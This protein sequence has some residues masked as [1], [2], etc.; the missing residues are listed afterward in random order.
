MSE[1]KLRPSEFGLSGLVCIYVIRFGKPVCSLRLKVWVGARYVCLT[2]EPTHNG[3]VWG[4]REWTP[5]KNPHPWTAKGA[6]PNPRATLRGLGVG[7]I[8]TENLREPKSWH[9][10]QRYKPKSIG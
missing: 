8:G 2:Q 1:L 6:A 4:T 5:G 10:S 3:G 7:H 9:E